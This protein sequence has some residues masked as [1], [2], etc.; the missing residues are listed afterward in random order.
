MNDT[1]TE[2]TLALQAYADGTLSGQD[3]LARWANAPPSYL[4]VYYHLFHLVD[5]ED[6]R[7]RDAA[8]R[9]RQTAQ[10]HELID[11][12]HRQAAPET[13]KTICFL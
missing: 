12:L 10:L 4:P 13:L 7:A 2:L 9:S 5:D 6:I 3:L 8:Y 1:L 11:A